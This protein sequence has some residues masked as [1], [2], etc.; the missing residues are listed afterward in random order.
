[1]VRKLRGRAAPGWDSSF[2]ELGAD[3]AAHRALIGRFRQR[4]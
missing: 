1:V 3:G 2:H 4:L